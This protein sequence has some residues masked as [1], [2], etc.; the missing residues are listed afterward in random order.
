[1]SEEKKKATLE[2]SFA[3]IEM[4]I[5]Q[6]EG[7]EISLDDSFSLY[8]KGMEQL[9]VCNDMLDTVE[10]K[11]QIINEEGKLEEF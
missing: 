11:M 2:D 7:S 3:Q 10:K 4:I 1:M 8:Q 5:S 6:M 9:K